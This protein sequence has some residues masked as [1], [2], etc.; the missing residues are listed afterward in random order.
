MTSDPQRALA[1]W[2]EHGHEIDLVI[3]DVVMAKMRGPALVQ[4]MAEVE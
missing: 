3:C 2:S 1:I 4:R